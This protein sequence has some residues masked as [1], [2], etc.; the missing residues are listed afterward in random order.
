MVELDESL[1]TENKRRSLSEIYI[2]YA[3]RR[4]KNYNELATEIFNFAFKTIPTLLP[5]REHF[6]SWFEILDFEIFSGEIV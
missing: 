6:L 1:S 5:K 4:V 2:P 3:D